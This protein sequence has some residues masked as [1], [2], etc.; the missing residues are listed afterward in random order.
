M[1]DDLI[2]HIIC[3]LGKECCFGIAC[4]AIY[5]IIHICLSDRSVYS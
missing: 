2:D 4:S 1:C 5:I 3:A